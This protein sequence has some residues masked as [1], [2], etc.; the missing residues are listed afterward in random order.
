[1]KKVGDFPINS[2]ISIDYSNGKPEVTFGYPEKEN[3]LKT[4]HRSSGIYILSILFACVLAIIFIL[5]FTLLSPNPGAVKNCSLYYNNSSSNY[6]WAGIITCQDADALN[7]K[8][9]YFID[10]HWPNGFT[11]STGPIGHDFLIKYRVL[12]ALTIFIIFYIINPYLLGLFFA[13]TK[14]GNR[15]YPKFNRL[16]LT[17][18]FS[19]EFT[20][21]P[22]SKVIELPLF[23]NIYLDYEADGQFGEY[24]QKIEIIEHDFNFNTKI[25][26]KKVDMKNI[27]L[28]KARFIFKKVP[29]SG[30]GYLRLKWT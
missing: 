25:G 24:L 16:I 30:D 8:L 23:S 9:Y 12:F 20:T 17:K 28:W 27:F 4:F 5:A 15:L 14:V 6:F 19:A 22:K 18:R 29:K 3:Q 21:C 7:H 11:I 26:R 10:Y 1:M 2:R 13:K